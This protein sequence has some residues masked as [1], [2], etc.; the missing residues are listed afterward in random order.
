MIQ[1]IITV[2]FVLTGLL[3]RDY[4][5]VE[6]FCP[7]VIVEKTECT[8]NDIS[9]YGRV[10]FV[11]SFPDI[12]IEYVDA[13]PDIRVEFV[14][15]FPDGCGRWQIVEAFPDFTVQIVDA[16]PD[17]RVQQVNSFPRMEN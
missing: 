10:Q 9:L 17:V 3:A 12:K 15:A 2:Q 11:Q 16:F 8:Y 5:N 6:E 14:E 1:Y 4:P 13:F 7:D